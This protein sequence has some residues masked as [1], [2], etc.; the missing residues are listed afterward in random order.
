MASWRE[1]QNYDP[2]PW[3]EIRGWLAGNPKGCL[4]CKYM[5]QRKRG[6]NAIVL[7]TR[8]VFTPDS[9]AMFCHYG[10]FANAVPKD[11]R[12]VDWDGDGTCDNW[13]KK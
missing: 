3:H 11:D 13:E 8:G 1:E 9:P 10:Q 7:T 12:S 2:P 4:R 6:G 5:R